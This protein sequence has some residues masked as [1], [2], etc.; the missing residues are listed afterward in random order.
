MKPKLAV[1]GS[2]ESIFSRQDE[3]FS[4]ILEIIS[5]TQSASVRAA[6]KL[7]ALHIIKIGVKTLSK[8]FFFFPTSTNA[9]V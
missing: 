8:M 4:F 9:V 7:N 6:S 3:F 5:V 1:F 2:F